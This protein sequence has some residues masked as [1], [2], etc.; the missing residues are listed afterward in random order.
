MVVVV[1]VV[2]VCGVWCVCVCVWVLILVNVNFKM[3]HT[4]KDLYSRSHEPTCLHTF[5]HP[6]ILTTT[7]I[8]THTHIHIHNTP[9][10]HAHKDTLTDT[11]GF[12]LLFCNQAR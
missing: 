7:S 5:A 3:L 8:N 11:G 1:V 10:T 4:C 9:H 6:F 12:A 2:V